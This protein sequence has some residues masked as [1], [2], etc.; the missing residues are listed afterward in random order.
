MAKD[1][2]RLATPRSESA[3]CLRT[4]STAARSSAPSHSSWLSAARCES[5]CRESPRCRTEFST[6]KSIPSR[7]TPTAGRSRSLSADDGDF[8]R[9]PVD[10][11]L[12][13]E[14]ARTEMDSHPERSFRKADFL[15][16]EA[17]FCSQSS[18]NWV[19]SIWRGL[20]GHWP[21]GH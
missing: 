17:R 16:T 19:R 6:E 1:A 20:M 4:W 18:W 9:P 10:L 2:C 7:K 5:S 3:T 13:P 14:C 8:A 12:W 15:Q 11:P 21:L